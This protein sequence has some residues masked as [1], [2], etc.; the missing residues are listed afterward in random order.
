MKKLFGN[1]FRKTDEQPVIIVSGLPRSGT[2]MMMAALK[3]GGIAIVTDQIRIADDDNPKGYYEFEP[4]KKLQEGDY[5]W[6]PETRGKAI[7][8][9][10]ALLTDLPD[11]YTYKLIFMRRAMPEILASQRKM[12]VNRGEDPDAINDEDMAAYFEAHLGEIIAWF[13]ARYEELR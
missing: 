11:G 12:L 10:S 3:A 5:S 7:K 8:V 6:L 13:H 2:S 4:V 1:L 9:I